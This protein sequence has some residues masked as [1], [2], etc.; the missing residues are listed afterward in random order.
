[1]N[2]T[3]PIIEKNYVLSTNTEPNHV[4]INMKNA[5]EAE[6]RLLLYFCHND[7]E[8]LPAIDQEGLFTIGSYCDH[9]RTLQHNQNPF[10]NNRPQPASEY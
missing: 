4:M 1:M 7:E 9:L 10:R 6:E 2:F 5:Y 3:G 8:L